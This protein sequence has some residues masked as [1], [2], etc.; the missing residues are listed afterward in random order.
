[1]AL[2]R[3]LA[4]LFLGVAV[5]VERLQVMRALPVVAAVVAVLLLVVAEHLLRVLPVAQVALTV[6][7]ITLPAVAVVPLQ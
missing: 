6:L 1:M 5:G 2:H 7:V 4:V 3:S